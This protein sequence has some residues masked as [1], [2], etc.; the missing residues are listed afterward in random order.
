MMSVPVPR[1]VNVVMPGD[2]IIVIVVR[3]KS[4]GVIVVVRRVVPID[5]APMGRVVRCMVSAAE[6]AIFAV[7]AVG[8]GN[9]PVLRSVRLPEIDVNSSRPK[10]D[11]LRLTG[12]WG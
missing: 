3:L 6:A 7:A 1:A 4:A 11:A 2:V 9:I 8:L 12:I 10:M 5:V